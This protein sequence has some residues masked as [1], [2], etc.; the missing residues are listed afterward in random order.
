MY[1]VVIKELELSLFIGI[2]PEEKLTQ[3]KLLVSL[4]L[5]VK[6]IKKL[7]Q[8]DKIDYAVDYEKLSNKII[9][10]FEGKQINLIETVA[11]KI[12]QICLEN[13]LI[14]SCNVT[15]AKPTAIEKAKSVS[16]QVL[17]NSPYN[18]HLEE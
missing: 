12:G 2:H 9:K 18:V 3:Q 17:F 7:A 13:C 16:V 8:C 6:G 15:V 4:E 5:N 11:E 14:K 10:E 1:K